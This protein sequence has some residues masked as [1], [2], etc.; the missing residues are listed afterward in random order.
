M[1]QVRKP[2][3]GFEQVLRCEINVANAVL[4]WYIVIRNLRK[5]G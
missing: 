4:A 1:I 3:E 2:C 5:D